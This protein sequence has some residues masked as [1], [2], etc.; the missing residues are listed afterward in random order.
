LRRGITV[1]GE[2]FMGMTVTIDRQQGSNAWLTVSLQEGRN[3]EIRRAMTAVYLTVNRLIRVSYGPFRLGDMK[4]GAV[5][6][7]RAKIVRD[8]LGLDGAGTA[9]QKPKRERRP[10]RN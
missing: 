9:K 1:D 5:D 10:Q 7:V 2:R 6:E 4:P 8:Q 3:R